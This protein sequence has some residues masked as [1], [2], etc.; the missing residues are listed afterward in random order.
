[1]EKFDDRLDGIQI[2]RLNRK[3]LSGFTGQFIF[4]LADLLKHGLEPRSTKEPEHHF[5]AEVGLGG[6]DPAATEKPREI[7]GGWV[8]SIQ[9]SE[10]GNEEQDR[11]RQHALTY[12]TSLNEY[13]VRGL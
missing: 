2:G 12:H 5:D 8:G 6:L 11:G 9:L 1:L 3:H 7:G 10:R 4:A 13:Q